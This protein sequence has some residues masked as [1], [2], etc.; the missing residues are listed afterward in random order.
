[1]FDLLMRDKTEAQII[2]DI[3]ERPN[4]LIDYDYFEQYAIQY[5]QDSRLMY[6]SCLLNEQMFGGG[7]RPE[8]FLE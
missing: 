8:R 6:Y 5:P 2:K 3:F 7:G 1:M 4:G